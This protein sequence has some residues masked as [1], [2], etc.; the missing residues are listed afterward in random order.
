MPGENEFDMEGALSEISGGL[1]LGNDEGESSSPSPD[2]GLDELLPET[3]ETEETTET[4]A[5]APA[6]PA[7]TA[8]AVPPPAPRT[9]RAEA[10][11]EWEK[12][13]AGVQAEILKREDDMF[14]G[15]ETYKAD[16]GLGKVIKGVL[17]PYIPT[18]QKYGLDPVVQVQNLMQAHYKLALGT[19]EEKASMFFQLAKDY[20]IQ[21]G[22]Q[23]E[24]PYVDPQVRA[25]QTELNGIK[26]SLKTQEERTVAEIRNK[27]TAEID[28]FAADPKHTYFNEV[29][30]DVASLLRSGAAKDLSDAYDKAIW[31]NPL[32]RAKEQ[33]RLTAETAATL[34]KEQADKIAAAK[35]ASAAN[36]KVKQKAVSGTAPLG[37][38]DSTLQETLAAINARG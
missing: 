7:P 25:L 2:D 21:I 4:A 20:G 14:K 31:A 29:M 36:V 10:A 23:G 18:M 34:K 26:S 16:A 38:M 35:K 17:E 8:A 28:A 1:G 22:D 9:W 12:L 32:T 5:K 30:D 19:P 15:I 3:T 27:L 33:A 13:P 37:S 11:A 6:D 24:T